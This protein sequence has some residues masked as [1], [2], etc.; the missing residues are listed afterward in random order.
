MCHA[1]QDEG[2]EPVIATTD[3]DG[4]GRLQVECG[5]PVP[6]HQIPTLFFP[7]QWSEA[8][9]FSYP[10]ARWLDDNI[11]QFD[12]VHIHAVFSHAC[13]AAARSCRRHRVP[14][15]V[16]PLGTLDPV[17]PAPEAVSQTALLAT[18]G[19]AHAGRSCSHSLHCRRGAAFG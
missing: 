9:K 17:E 3:A 6:F 12:V 1:L 11:S 5:K 4:A 19:Q 10:L 8:L 7:R 18:G 2:L 16:R 15:I 13:L 14:C